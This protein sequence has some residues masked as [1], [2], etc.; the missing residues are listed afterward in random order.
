MTVEIIDGPTIVI[1]MLDDMDIEVGLV[2]RQRSD[3]AGRVC[4]GVSPA[5]RY[6]TLAHLKDTYRDALSALDAARQMLMTSVIWKT[7]L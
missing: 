7:S 2:T 3:F 1:D 4:F 6:A 5:G